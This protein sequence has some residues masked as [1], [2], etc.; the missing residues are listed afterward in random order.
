MTRT[1]WSSRPLQSACPRIRRW[2]T[3]CSEMIRCC[4]W[5]ERNVLNRVGVIHESDVVVVGPGGSGGLLVNPGGTRRR[6]R[7]GRRHHHHRRHQGRLRAGRRGQRSR[8]PG[9]VRVDLY[10][11]LLDA[12]SCLRLSQRGRRAGFSRLSGDRDDVVP[13]PYLQRRR[14]RCDDLGLRAVELLRGGLQAAFK[15]A[16]SGLQFFRR[17]D[18]AEAIG[19]LR[20]P[21]SNAGDV[22]G[23]GPRAVLVPWRST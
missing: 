20:F 18:V 10:P 6:R 5:T 4:A 12:Q 17:D 16:D 9:P 15:S 1:S 11:T 13:A 8:V 22:H 3:R 19:V 14:R 23:G 7:S 2:R 21:G